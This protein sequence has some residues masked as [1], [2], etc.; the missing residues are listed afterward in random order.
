MKSILKCSLITGYLCLLSC[1]SCSSEKIDV[2]YPADANIYQKD[3]LYFVTVLEQTHPGF[4]PEPLPFAIRDNWDA[5][6]QETYTALSDTTSKTDFFFTI[7][8][9]AHR[10]DDGHTRIH[11]PEKIPMTFLP[12]EFGIL[13]GALYIIAVYD[14]AYADLRYQQVLSINGSPA[15]TIITIAGMHTTSDKNNTGWKYRPLSILTML[16]RNSVFYEYINLNPHHTHVELVTL[17]ENDTEKHVQIDFQEQFNTAS[18]SELTN[19]TRNEITRFSDGNRYQLLPEQSVM[20]IQLNRLPS[21]VDP[22]FFTAIF[23]QANEHGV[24]TLL[25]DLRNNSGGNSLWCDEFLKHL[26]PK[27][28]ELSIYN[29]WRR[30]GD[31]NIGGGSGLQKIKAKA[32]FYDGDVL[33]LTSPR[34]F[35]S[36]TFFVVAI[37]D[38]QLGTIIG[39]PCGNNHVRYG[40]TSKHTLP[41]TGIRCSTSIRIWDRAKK[42]GL[43]IDTPL[44]PDILVE[45]TIDDMRQKRDAV[46]DYTMQHHLN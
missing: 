32:P 22:K 4:A 34:T 16:L 39:E 3:F 44:F 31:K 13:Q 7:S 12:I 29:G 6:V 10:L 46:F 43:Q 23:E 9:F 41:F 24:Q 40:Y 27:T 5:A 11:P 19:R 38:N 21:K 37:Q 45:T 30:D 36:A 14:D 33:V 28:T 17:A 15:E 42:D 1:V 18:L 20:Y 25:L 35:S 2:E 8:Q 26:V